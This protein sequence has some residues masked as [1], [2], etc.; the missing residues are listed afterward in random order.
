MGT[1]LESKGAL[2]SRGIEVGL[3][4]NEIDDIINGGTTS[5]ARLAFAA[6]PP[7]TTPSD[8]QVRNLFSV[9][10]AP[11]VGTLSSLKRLIFEAQTLVV[12]DVKSKVTKKDD[13][14]PSNMAPAER[15]N[16]IAEQRRRLT[17][18][19]LRGEEEVGH[20]V[21]DMLMTMAEKDVIVYHA[22]ERFHTR[23]QELL[24][25]KPNKELA[26]DASQL[27]V[28]E[29]NAEMTCPTGTELEVVNALR[30]RALAYDLTQLCPY[31]VMNSYH[32]ELIDHLSQPAP[33]G[34]SPVSIHQI[35]R[36]DR[37][38][39]MLMSERLTTLKKDANG[40]TPI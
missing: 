15:E 5:L 14:M 7:G 1:L 32:A 39:F 4:D 20:A 9:A 40:K 27:V 36:A 37:Q 35:L 8:E 11:N 22:P 23:R 28:R 26:I 3:T 34:Y 38:A 2:R 16:R 33:P 17:G 19:R 21:Y 24:N 30:R 25:K 12:A 13:S 10:V 18:L 29:K 6:S 31:E